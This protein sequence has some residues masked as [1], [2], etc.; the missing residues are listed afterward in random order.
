MLGLQSGDMGHTAV[1]VL[2]GMLGLLVD[3]SFSALSGDRTATCLFFITYI[4]AHPGRINLMQ[5]FQ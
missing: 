1:F 2:A 3:D 5:G 4:Q